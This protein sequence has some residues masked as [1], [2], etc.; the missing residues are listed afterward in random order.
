MI[1]DDLF[2]NEISI[3]IPVEDSFDIHGNPLI[4][5]EV[6]R[7]KKMAKSEAFDKLFGDISYKYVFLVKDTS[8]PVEGS[9]MTYMEKRYEV[10]SVRE[11]VDIHDVHQCWRVATQ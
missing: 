11:C 1:L 8:E 7:A 4:T 3:D 5:T 6:G 2:V 9:Y 10:R